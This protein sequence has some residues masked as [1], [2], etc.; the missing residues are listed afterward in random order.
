MGLLVLTRHRIA[1]TA[2]PGQLPMAALAVATLS[3]SNSGMPAD[4]LVLHGQNRDVVNEKGTK[5]N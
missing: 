1:N 2:A 4:M 5:V 3:S